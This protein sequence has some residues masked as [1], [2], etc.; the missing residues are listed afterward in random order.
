MKKIK[1]SQRAII[2]LLVSI[3][4]LFAIDRGLFALTFFVSGRNM[5]QFQNHPSV[6]MQVRIDGEIAYVQLI[7]NSDNDKGFGEQFTL[8]RRCGWRWRR[9]FFSGEL[10]GGVFWHSIAYL[11][12]ANEHGIALDIDLSHYFGTLR[13]GEYRIVKE[14]FFD[15]TGPRG[16]RIRVA[17]EFTIS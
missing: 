16:D 5:E 2:F 11:L 10:R 6:E 9:V 1:L 13:R 4:A 17:G 12:P 7:N 14:V 8:Y 15:D 3:I